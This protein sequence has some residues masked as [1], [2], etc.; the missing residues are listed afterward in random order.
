MAE[1]SECSLTETKSKLEKLK[2][3]IKQNRTNELELENA[4]LRR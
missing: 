4:K 3:A 2:R 1:R